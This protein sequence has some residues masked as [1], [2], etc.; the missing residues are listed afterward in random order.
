MRTYDTISIVDCLS[1]CSQIQLLETDNG[2]TT[3]G[4]HGPHQ[5]TCVDANSRIGCGVT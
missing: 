1:L 4:T 3:G 2:K 5:I